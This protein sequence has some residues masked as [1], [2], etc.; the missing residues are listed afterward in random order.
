M[1][2]KPSLKI[3][4]SS[5]DLA[6]FDP[7]VITAECV[8]AGIEFWTAAD[9][10][11]EV[12]KSI[13]DGISTKD[14]QT[15][16]E[17]VLTERSPEAAERYRRFHSMLIR[18]S[19]NTIEPFDR[20]RIA[21]S[22][23]KETRLPKELA[24]NIAKESEEELRRLKLDFIS[25]PLIREVVNVKLLEHGF[26]DA[27]ADY[28]RLGMPVY[29]AVQLIETGREQRYRSPQALHDAMADNVLREYALLKVLP[30]HQADS[31]MRGE[32]HVHELEHFVTKPYSFRHGLRR[33]FLEGL[34]VD[35]PHGKVVSNPAK[36]AVS[37]FAQVERLLEVCRS[38]FSGPQI[39]GD[40]NYYLAPFVS[41]LKDG[42]VTRLS[43][44]FL[45][46]VS[47]SGIETRISF[48]HRCP[49]S[50]AGL[51]AIGPGGK[52]R[53]KYSDYQEEALALQEAFTKVLLDGDG[54]GNPFPY[55]TPM[56]N[57]EKA[58]A[59]EYEA[60]MIPGHKLAIK[61]G[62]PVFVAPNSVRGDIGC[63][64][65]VSLNIPRVAY[66]ANGEDKFYEILDDRLAMAREVVMVKRDVIKKRLEH[67]MLP[68]LSD[69]AE[70]QRYTLDDVSHEIAFFGIN[71][72]VKAQ[73]DMEL[74]ESND[75]WKFGLNIVR[76]IYRC[77]KEWSEETQLK[78]TLVGSTEAVARRL[79]KLDYGQFS[80]RAM[81]GDHE[82]PNYTEACSLS[83]EANLTPIRQLQMEGV[84]HPY[85][86]VVARATPPS[87]SAKVLM[88]FNKKIV[89]DTEL[90][91]WRFGVSIDG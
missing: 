74:H 18:T 42:G 89:E 49:D 12:S 37:A 23:I 34:T 45:Y 75:A 69:G 87:E 51:K 27:R 67:G 64:Q 83:S 52:A 26:E 15:T 77:L 25:A 88:N 39:L 84:F 63:L 80:N 10:A 30:L 76:H 9:A 31:H 56:Y 19:R 78:W 32:I 46:E 68:F 21:N 62:T 11:L 57:L 13:Y 72:A 91:S 6:I 16:L 14:L 5:G 41:G 81:I 8:E 24:E 66:E 44:L 60:S 43:R 71:E 40:L 29:D 85:C 38:Y 36:D 2:S 65:K 73:T 22:L 55:I 86:E 1:A 28:T 47:Q 48:S 20:K 82:R 79:A 33:L 70:G 61:F 59:D 35:S 4:K 3:V 58:W 7:N 17:K 54:A 50:I 53:G 90:G